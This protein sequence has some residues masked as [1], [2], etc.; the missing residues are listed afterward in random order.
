MTDPPVSGHYQRRRVNPLAA[1]CDGAWKRRA[2][3]VQPTQRLHRTV[4]VDLGLLALFMILVWGLF[5]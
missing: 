1:S 5:L 4:P 2:A 3:T